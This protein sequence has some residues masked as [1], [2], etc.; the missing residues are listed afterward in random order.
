M[1][2]PGHGHPERQRHLGRPGSGHRPGGLVTSGAHAGP[3]AARS[4]PMRGSPAACP[5]RLGPA[6]HA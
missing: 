3:G 1:A 5:R 6:R 2:D 4:S